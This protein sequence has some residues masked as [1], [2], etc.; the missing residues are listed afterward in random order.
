MTR[1]EIVS[2]RFT[3]EERIQLGRVAQRLGLRP[4][5]LAREWVLAR[6]GPFT[7]A[8]PDPVPADAGTGGWCAP[9]DAMCVC[10]EVW[11]PTHVCPVRQSANAAPEYGLPA[12]ARGAL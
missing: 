3:E 10:G 8:T 9:A 5:Q 7:A 1:D 11:G 12:S 6:L 4:A 2:V